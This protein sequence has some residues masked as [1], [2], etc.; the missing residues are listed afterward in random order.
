MAVSK[1]GRILE[2]RMYSCMTGV[3][4]DPYGLTVP[5]NSQCTLLGPYVVPAYD[6]TFTAVFTNLPDRHALSRCPDGN[7]A[8]S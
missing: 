7:M 5:L 3:P 4:N 1:D 6:S 8:S 2:S